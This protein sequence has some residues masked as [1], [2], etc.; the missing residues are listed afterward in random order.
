MIGSAGRFRA[1]TRINKTS[2][3]GGAPQVNEVASA[4]A[5][6]MPYI[7]GALGAY[8]GAVLSRARDDAADA[9]VSLGRRIVQRIFGVRE[10][11]SELPEALWDVVDDPADP[12]AVAA[13]RLQVRKMLAADPQLFADVRDMLA[14]ARINVTALGKRSVA[15][16]VINAP[17]TTGNNSPI[18]K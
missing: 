6:V 5:E 12:D 16:Q 9:T 14:G 15:A 11:R 7:T 4:A 17:V 10:D 18:D 2:R 1:L 3:P 13:L 8:G